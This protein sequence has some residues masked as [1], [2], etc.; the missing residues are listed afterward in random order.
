MPDLPRSTADVYSLLRDFD[1][2]EQWPVI[3]GADI[4]LDVDSQHSAV[5]LHIDV[6]KH[7]FWFDGHFP[8]HPVLPGIVQVNWAGE[9]SRRLFAPDLVFCDLQAI[10]FQQTISPQATVILN[11]GYS[12]QRTRAV[13]EYHDD[14]A[15]VFSSGRIHFREPDG[16]PC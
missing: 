13:F 3:T 2:P 5:K 10:K 14:D 12:R 11:I 15:A 9:I 16:D 8:E 7:R 6:P 1:N 4:D